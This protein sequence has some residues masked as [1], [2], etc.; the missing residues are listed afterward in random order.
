MVLNEGGFAF[1]NTEATFTENLP[2]TLP[3][4]SPNTLVTVNGKVVRF[5]AGEAFSVAPVADFLSAHPE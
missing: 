5:E 3:F 4:T 1:V 2:E